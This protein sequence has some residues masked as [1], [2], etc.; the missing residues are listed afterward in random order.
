MKPQ[1]AVQSSY[2]THYICQKMLIKKYNNIAVNVNPEEIH[3][4]SDWVKRWVLSMDLNRSTDLALR[5][6]DGSRFHSLGAAD[7]KARSP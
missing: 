5:M 4:H 6:L 1:G 2:Y 7:E 3:W